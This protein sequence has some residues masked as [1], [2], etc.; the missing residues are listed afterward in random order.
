MCVLTIAAPETHRPT[1]CL[2]L[3]LDDL[4][5]RVH[6]V[7]LPMRVRFRGI[8]VREVALI[9]GPAGWGEFGAF[10]EYG[11]RRG[12]ALAG[13]CCRVRLRHEHRPRGVTASR[14]TPPFRRCPLRRCPTCSP[15]SR[16]RAPPRS[17]SPSRGRRWPMTSPG[18]TPCAHWSRRCGWTPTAAGAVRRGGGRGA[19]A[20]RRRAAGVPGAAVCAASPNW[21]NCAAASTIPWPPTRAS[22]RP[23]T[24]CVSSRSAAADIAVLKVAPLG[25]VSSPVAD[26]R[27]RSISRS[28]CRAPWTPR[29]ASAAGCWPLLP[30]RRCGTRAGW[31]PADCSS[32]TSSNLSR[33]STAICR[34]GAVIPDPARLAAARP[35]RGSAPLVDRADHR[36][37]P[38]APHPVISV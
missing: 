11:P 19:R 15:G 8:T 20:D 3:A 10:L 7:A 2:M 5:D 33:P 16:V 30:A 28:W 13:I 24:R 38:A 27:A 26:R 6:V 32:R 31:A 37:L 4:L 18:S 17:R 34:S 35:H 36:L 14:S 25:G 29:S 12:R 23:T 22:A 9:D 1:I 21:P